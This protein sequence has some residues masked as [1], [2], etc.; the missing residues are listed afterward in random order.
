MRT[1]N[2]L[3]KD[4][5]FSSMVD[6]NTQKHV[7]HISNEF[8]LIFDKKIKVSNFNNKIKQIALIFMAINPKT[9]SFR[10][11][12]KF[13]RWKAGNFDMYLNVPNY[14]FFCTATKTEARKII[15]ELYLTGI[16]KY[17]SKQKDFNHELFYKDVKEL[18]L[19]E[20]II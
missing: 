15:A 8:D 3:K 9:H 11:D 17:L 12:K 2:S 19:K 16:K 4:I 6:M 18:F 7:L 10:P 1:I 5:V 14:Q 13:W 20:G